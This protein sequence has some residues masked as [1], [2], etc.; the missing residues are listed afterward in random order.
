VVTVTGGWQDHP[1]NVTMKQAFAPSIMDNRVGKA[2][3]EGYLLKALSRGT[4]FTAPE[5][6]I[7]GKGLESLQIG[8]GLQHKGVSAQKVVILL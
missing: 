6:L 7:A 5:P 1:K 8:V 4:F 2:I 3:F